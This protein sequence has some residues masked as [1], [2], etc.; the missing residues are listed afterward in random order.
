MHHNSKH[1]VI[2]QKATVSTFHQLKN[3]NTAVLALLLALNS[4]VLVAFA[5][6]RPARAVVQSV[7][8]MRRG[9][10]CEPTLRKHNHTR[11]APSAAR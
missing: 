10:C 8:H 11:T 3:Y 5:G 1:P 6:C 9:S 4:Q 2:Q 7:L